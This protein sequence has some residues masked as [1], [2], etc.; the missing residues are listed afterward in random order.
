VPSRNAE[1]VRFAIDCFNRDDF[2]RGRTIMHPDVHWY[3]SGAFP[4][5]DPVYV[6]PDRVAVWWRDFQDPWE[7]FK[8]HVEREIEQ[9]DRTITLVRFEAI[10]KESGVQVN[11]QFGQLFEF[12]DGLLREFRSFPSW[13]EALAAAS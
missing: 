10:G 1:L 3:S 4:G 5:L 11:L 8:I 7:S 6:G 12:E 9:G 2:E 13:D